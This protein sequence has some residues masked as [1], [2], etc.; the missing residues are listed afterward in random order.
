M[1]RYIE[2][3]RNKTKQKKEKDIILSMLFFRYKLN[4]L[5]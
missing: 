1:L 4:I 3:R 5:V 2:T